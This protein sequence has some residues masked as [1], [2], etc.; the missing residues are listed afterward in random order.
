M[1]FRKLILATLLPLLSN[2][3]VVNASPLLENDIE[4][5]G[6]RKTFKKI[7]S[8]GEF[9]SKH[10]ILVSLR[11]K[12]HHVEKKFAYSLSVWK[13]K[14][15]SNDEAW[16]L[17]FTP[18]HPQ[19]DLFRFFTK[20][21]ANKLKGPLTLKST[22]ELI[23]HNAVPPDVEIIDLKATAR[24][25]SEEQV[26]PG[27]IL[28]IKGPA[29]KEEGTSLYMVEAMLKKLIQGKNLYHPSNP[30]A[31]PVELTSFPSIWA[32]RSWPYSRE[33]ERVAAS[34]PSIESAKSFGSE[35]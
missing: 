6:L 9:C 30:P 16:S 1:L 31:P 20:P 27:L 35:I 28:P 25:A 32:T 15:G 12:E 17:I 13:N 34:R 7:V 23:K 33:G 14:K 29:S 26:G 24:F 5:R 8:P 21:V 10:P 2:L 4:P 11:E 18:P 3:L 19:A 22:F